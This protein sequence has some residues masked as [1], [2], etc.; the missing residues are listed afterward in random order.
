VT[1][2]LLLINV[3]VDDLKLIIVQVTV[4]SRPLYRK[5][6]IYLCFIV[7]LQL[8]QDGFVLLKEGFYHFVSKPRNVEGSLGTEVNHGIEALFL[9]LAVHV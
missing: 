4:D 7:C 8:K 9:Y 3:L 5:F 2:L 6:W 1:H